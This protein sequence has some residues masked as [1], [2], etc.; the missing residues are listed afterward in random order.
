[1]MSTSPPARSALAWRSP[2]SPRSCRTTSRPRSG[3]GSAARPHGGAGGRCGAGRGQY[4]RDAAGRLE[5]RPAQHLVDHRLQPPVARRGRARR[6]VRRV[7]KIFD[8]FGW[9]VVQGQIRRLQR[10]AFSR[11]RRRKLR[12][13]I[14]NC[15]PNQLYSALTFMGGAV[16]RKRLMDDLGD[17]GD[18]TA[19]IESRSDE[20]LAE[21]MENLGGNC[22]E[23]MADAFA[24]DR[25]RP[26]DLLSRLHDQGLGHADCRPQGQSRRADEQGP[27]GRVAG[28][29]GRARGRGVGA[30][31]H[32]RRIRTRSRRSSTGCRSS[33]R[34]AA[35]RRPCGSPPQI[36]IA[37]D[38]EI[39]T[40]AAFGKIL[41]D[42]PRAT[43]SSPRAS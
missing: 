39:S 11:T 21:L 33:P 23:T 6:P 12:E 34:A 5:E 14:D 27:D 2:R 13:W 43:A 26:A 1:M 29:H 15:L 37:T 4:L 32:R 36:E 25:P 38:R 40:Q 16:W 8:A 41:D 30:V 42:L 35:L 28:A 18:V 19:L 17:Q 22:V 3:A 31:R 7:E 20:E 24:S 10:A 9:D